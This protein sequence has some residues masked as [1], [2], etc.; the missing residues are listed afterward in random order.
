MRS[1]IGLLAAIVTLAAAS[2]SHVPAS[3]HPEPVWVGSLSLVQD[4]SGSVEGHSWSASSTITFASAQNISDPAKTTMTYSYTW[5]DTYAAPPGGCSLSFT[6]IG[7]GVVPGSV[8]V[9]LHGESTY[10]LA[11]TPAEMTAY[12]SIVTTSGPDNCAGTIEGTS[13]TYLGTQSVQV[14]DAIGLDPAS[15]AG[16]LEVQN[17]QGITGPVTVSWRLTQ[18]GHETESGD[19]D[20]DGATDEEET[21]LG[22]DP[23][24]PDTDGGGDNDGPEI[25]TG[26]DPLDPSDDDRDDDG[27]T[28]AEEGDLGTD[29]ANPDTDSDSVNDGIDDC[30][31]LSGTGSDGC[32]PS[33]GGGGPA[34]ACNVATPFSEEAHSEG[35]NQ[36]APTTVGAMSHVEPIL[37]SGVASGTFEHGFHD[38]YQKAHPGVD[39]ADES[40]VEDF[41]R[42]F[43]EWKM[44][45]G[46]R[47]VELC[48]TNVWSF[49]TES[50]N[51]SSAPWLYPQE[52]APGWNDVTWTI[53]P[54]GLPTL[55]T[56]RAHVCRADVAR[57]VLPPP[58]TPSPGR[59]AISMSAL[60]RSGGTD[61]DVIE[62]TQVVEVYL[63]TQS[64]AART[65]DVR[66]DLTS[67]VMLDD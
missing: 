29:P 55:F 9:T 22:T 8:G 5:N 45:D 48:V 6:Y 4:V 11:S 13:G 62:H 50:L 54:T 17:Q 18:V 52:G 44:F 51:P 28:N 42:F 12:R 23:N 56:L 16:A 3:A 46:S 35:V 38:R 37:C 47:P 63:S 2:L 66:H 64:Q 67:T 39:W 1:R 60:G 27:A 53:I 49:R 36:N 59:Y 14:T 61:I 31:L 58:G 65:P 40:E 15:L 33:G 21:D 32:N 19:S 7:A 25:S 24:N 30:P 10:T 41:G 57:I 20:G 34:P 26:T 43:A